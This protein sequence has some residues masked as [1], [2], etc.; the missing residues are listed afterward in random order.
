MVTKT[1]AVEMAAFLNDRAWW[2][3]DGSVDE[4]TY[5]DDV[6]ITVNGEIEDDHVFSELPPAT[7]VTIEG[8]CVYG[9]VVGSVEPGLDTYL[10]RWRK[11]QT[12]AFVGLHLPKD[13]LD[14]LKAFVKTAGGEM[15]SGQA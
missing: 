4:V 8:G 14:L 3:E 9:K 5:F 11:A 12:T 13:K 2:K 6:L 15:F 1:T 10:K 7:P